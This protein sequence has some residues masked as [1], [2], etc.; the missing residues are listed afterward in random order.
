MR[1]LLLLSLFTL[2]GTAG[3]SI[4]IPAESRYLKSAQDRATEIEVQKQLGMPLARTTV[5]TGEAVWLYEVLEEQ[6]THRGTPTGFWCDEY[7]LTFDRNQVLRQWGHRSFFHGGEL[8]PEPCHAGY[9]RL[10]L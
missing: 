9:E 1:H 3:C 8:R 6:P 7:R 2:V 10:A 4:L 5:S